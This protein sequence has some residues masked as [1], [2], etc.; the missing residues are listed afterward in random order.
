MYDTKGIGIDL[1]T[2]S[3]IER[4]CKDTNEVF[5]ER[6]FSELERA[7][8]EEAANR[9]EFL[10]GRFAVKEAVFKAISSYDLNADFDFRIIETEK[11]ENGAPRVVVNK[12]LAEVMSKAGV[13]QVLVSISNEGDFAIA[14]AQVQ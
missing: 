5:A 3:E 7:Q 8:A 10:A 12:K 14:I 13:S 6:T 2:I 11:L 4:L 9:Y 1:V